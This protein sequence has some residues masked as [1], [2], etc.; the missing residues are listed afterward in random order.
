M[1]I[2]NMSNIA[3]SN[4]YFVSH[5]PTFQDG[6]PFLGFRLPAAQTFTSYSPSNDVNTYLQAVT[7]RGGWKQR[8]L[9]Q[10]DHGTEIL[11]KAVKNQLN[12]AVSN[13]DFPGYHHKASC[14][15]DTDCSDGQLCYVFNDQVLG[16]QH[17]PV[18]SDVVYPEI[19]LGNRFN[20]GIPLRQHSNFCESD[21]E[22]SGKD[23]YTGKPKKGMKC[24][25]YNKGPSMRS[26]IGMCQVEYES[27]GD[28]FFLEQPPGFTMPMN[29]P[30]QQC[31][32]D[33]D[34]G[35]TGINGW[36]RC[37]KAGD[38]NSYCTWSGQTVR[39]SGS[40]VFR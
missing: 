27:K 32:S 35:P 33:I 5:S 13:L 28:R 4:N 19:S 17:G 30:L 11:S 25:H 12:E 24:N 14:Q 23:K 36:T 18:C 1:I 26:D 22:C 37:K 15:R 16:S 3:D 29:E 39:R 34:C 20:Q 2:I 21:K 9:L 38:K 8:Q 7:G 10:S 31:N 6:S 40:T